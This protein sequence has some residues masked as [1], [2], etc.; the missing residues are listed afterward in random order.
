MQLKRDAN[1]LAEL[2]ALGSVAKSL[3]K[4]D[5]SDFLNS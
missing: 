5:K 1:E 3:K 4:K 2:Q